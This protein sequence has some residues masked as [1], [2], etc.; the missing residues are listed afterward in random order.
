MVVKMR[1]HTD[2]SSVKSGQWYVRLKE[3]LGAQYMG[4][5]FELSTLLEGLE[6]I[7]SLKATLSVRNLLI[8]DHGI[9]D[10]EFGCQGWP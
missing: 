2:C 1:L 7:T 3:N 10:L 9:L 5:N 6:F 8:L 4:Q